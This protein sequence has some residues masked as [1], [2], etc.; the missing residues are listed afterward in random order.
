MLLLHG[1]A[2]SPLQHRSLPPVPV[3]MLERSKF[4]EATLPKPTEQVMNYNPLNEL[5]LKGIS[6]RS[7]ER[8]AASY[9]S[10]PLMK[11]SIAKEKSDSTEKSVIEADQEPKACEIYTRQNTKHK[12]PLLQCKFRQ[13]KERDTM[14]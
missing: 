1:G 14:L 3:K 12:D 9:E 5:D 11:L 6:K 13:E 7:A 8:K 10:T 2:K 4:S